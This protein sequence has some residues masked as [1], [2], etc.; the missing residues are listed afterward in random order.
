MLHNMWMTVLNLVSSMLT[1][2]PMA[3]AATAG[4]AAGTAGAIDH[5]STESVCEPSV[6]VWPELLPE[7]RV[8]RQ[9]AELEAV[10]GQPY[11]SAGEN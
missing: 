5:N 7:H 9:G 6:F 2:Q 8:R 1:A 3:R 11:T 4:A 10:A